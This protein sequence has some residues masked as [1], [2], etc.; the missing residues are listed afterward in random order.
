MPLDLGLIV[1][2]IVS[3]VRTKS[4]RKPLEKALVSS[5]GH[6]KLL[7][8]IFLSAL[9]V[10]VTFTF[11]GKS[12][13]FY[14]VFFPGCHISNSH[15]T[16]NLLF[17]KFPHIFIIPCLFPA[18]VTNNGDHLLLFVNLYP[19]ITQITIIIYYSQLNL[20]H[21]ET[22]KEIKCSRSPSGYEKLTW[23]VDLY[24]EVKSSYSTKNFHTAM[25]MLLGNTGLYM[26]L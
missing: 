22:E 1:I 26:T 17:F 25:K 13:C 5:G 19:R 23:K 20:R 14:K 10:C 4:Y 6:S 18:W 3:S 2:E 9:C 21:T 7:L 11:L 24:A 15:A 8:V 16:Y 12:R